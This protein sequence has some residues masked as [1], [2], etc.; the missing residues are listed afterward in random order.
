MPMQFIYPDTKSLIV[1]F[2]ILIV[3][4]KALVL[5]FYFAQKKSGENAFS[6]TIRFTIG[7]FLWVCLLSLPSAFGNLQDKPFFAVMAFFLISNLGAILFSFSKIGTTISQNTS[8]CLLIAFQ[9]FRLPLELVLHHWAKIGT[10][11]M[12]MTWTGANFDIVSGILAIACSLIYMISKFRPI[13]WVFNIVGFLLLLNVMRVAV[14]SS[15]A[16]FGWKLA[17]PLQLPY[18]WPYA[19]IVPICVAG[20]LAGHILLTRALL[21]DSRH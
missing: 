14:L 4:L 6:K 10:I 8:I 5:G 2:L 16:P 15:N 17:S 3:V 18:H 19:L 12:T 13:A 20:A 7:L 11:P 9:I 1:F 21:R